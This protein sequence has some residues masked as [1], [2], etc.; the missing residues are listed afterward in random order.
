[1]TEGVSKLEIPLGIEEVIHVWLQILG[2]LD[3]STPLFSKHIFRISPGCLRQ[4]IFGDC[5]G[6]FDSM[7]SMAKKCQ[8]Y[9]WKDLESFASLSLRRSAFQDRLSSVKKQMFYWKYV[10]DNWSGS[11][12]IIGEVIRARKCTIFM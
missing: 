11:S 6:N 1:M 10:E 3:R 4:G 8:L 12:Y 2:R 5:L 7:I 9:Q